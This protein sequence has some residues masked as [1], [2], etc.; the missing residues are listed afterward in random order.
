MSR[1]LPRSLDD[2]PP[3]HRAEAL[4]QFM[5]QG[6]KAQQAIDDLGAGGV[7]PREAVRLE[8]SGKTDVAG[9]PSGQSLSSRRT[10]R[11][12]LSTDEAKLNKTERAFLQFLRVARSG[13]WIGVQNIT[14]KLADDTRYTPDLSCVGTQGNLHFWEVKGFWRDDARVKI[15]VAARMFP[16]AR[17]TAVQRIKGEWK[18]EEIKP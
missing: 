5:A 16:W 7:K 9:Q 1:H 17:F 14:L 2:L 11:P 13:C 18:F 6:L 10:A 4:R 3:Q 12:L 8:A 15:K